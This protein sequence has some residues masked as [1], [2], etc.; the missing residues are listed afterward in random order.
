MKKNKA[1]IIFKVFTFYESDQFLK[2]GT[3]EVNWKDQII[4]ERKNIDNRVDLW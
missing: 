4:F 2:L 1:L 3:F